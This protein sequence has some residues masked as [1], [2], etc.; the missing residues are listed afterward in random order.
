MKTILINL[1]NIGERSCSSLVS[2]VRCLLSSGQVVEG[3]LGGIVVIVIVNV[4]IVIVDVILVIV[5]LVMIVINV[6]IIDVSIVKRS[7][8]AT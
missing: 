1:V 3:N 6:I 5:M 7:S 4:M 8:K 2:S